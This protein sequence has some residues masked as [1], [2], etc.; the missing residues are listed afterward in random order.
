[1]KALILAAGEGTRLR[2]LT[3]QIPKPL[4]EVCG[5]PIL[6]YSLEQLRDKVEEV[7][8][9]VGYKAER[10]KEYFGNE[11]NGLKIAYAMQ[12]K[13]LG[14]ANA[15]KCARAF[16]E[17]EGRFFLLM[18]DSIYAKRD[19]KRCI[20]DG[21]CLLVAEVEEPKKF[22][23]VIADEGGYLKDIEEKPRN[24]RSNLA[25]TALYVLSGEIFGEIERLKISSR[26]E[27]DLPEAVVN[28][29]RRQPIL[30]IK[31]E[32]KWLPIGYPEELERARRIVTAREDEF[33]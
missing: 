17:R 12:E 11:F 31:A 20:E 16:L 22:G 24:P 19:V 30:C 28:L 18:G 33:I 9:V 15:V 7:I 5:R 25:N 1:M 26:G 29:S 3:Y 23:I 6:Q 2:P 27:Y 14:T 10:I 13:Q 21:L 4:I 8:I 32:G